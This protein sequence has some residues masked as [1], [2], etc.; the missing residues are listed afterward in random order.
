MKRVRIADVLEVYDEVYKREV[1][2]DINAVKDFIRSVAKLPP[3]VPHDEELV[4]EAAFNRMAA[5]VYT[6]IILQTLAEDQEAS[7][8][9][10]GREKRVGWL[11]DDHDHE[12]TSISN[13]HFGL[14]D[15]PNVG[16]MVIDLGGI[17]GGVTISTYSKPTVPVA[18]AFD[19]KNPAVK[20]WPLSD[21]SS[22]QLSQQPIIGRNTFPPI[23]T[24]S[25]TLP[26]RAESLQFFHRKVDH[27][28]K[29]YIDTA[30]MSPAIKQRLVNTFSPLLLNSLTVNLRNLNATAAPVSPVVPVQGPSSSQ[31]VYVDPVYTQILESTRKGL[32]DSFLDIADAIE[33]PLERKALLRRAMSTEDRFEDVADFNVRMALQ[34]ISSFWNNRNN[35]ASNFHGY[36]VS[37]QIEV[38]TIIRH[39]QAAIRALI[40]EPSKDVASTP[41]QTQILEASVSLE[42]QLFLA[43]RKNNPDEIRRLIDKGANPNVTNLRGWTPLFAACRSLKQEAVEALLAYPSVDVNIATLANGTTPLMTALEMS[44]QDYFQHSTIIDRLLERG[45]QV[46][47]R[48]KDNR[49]AVEILADQFEN[50]ANNGW[51]DARLAIGA[52]QYGERLLAL[53]NT[54]PEL[55]SQTM[56]STSSSASIECKMDFLNSMIPHR[57]TS[58]NAPTSSSSHHPSGLEVESSF[59]LSKTLIFRPIAHNAPTS[60]SRLQPS[61]SQVETPFDLSKTLIFRPIAHNAPTS[62]SRLQPSSSQ[63]ETPFD[64]LNTRI[65]RPTAHNAPTRSSMHQPSGSQVEES[66]VGNSLGFFAPAAQPVVNPVHNAFFEAVLLHDLVQIENMLIEDPSLVSLPNSAGDSALLLVTSDYLKAADADKPGILPLVQ[67]LLLRAADPQQENNERASPLSMALNQEEEA[68]VELMLENNNPTP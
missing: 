29:T 63:I 56:P 9:V 34:M 60:S 35:A 7:M 27:A 25:S 51:S 38:A 64:L 6:R 24:E 59:D 54:T 14:I 61:S 21:V 22:M 62:S 44:C 66:Q 43:V 5:K 4:Q 26:A 1:T 30:S 55:S 15:I 19:P 47:L 68:L 2:G 67:L 33:N 12:A 31:V 52:K 13:I 10:I 20:M 28:V 36:S 48:S 18:L 65:V 58:H 23:R 16:D 3:N 17:R 42:E 32:E 11:P 49:N 39:T 8:Y 41:N 46:R 45:A 37:A 50:M 57:L 40:E 53:M